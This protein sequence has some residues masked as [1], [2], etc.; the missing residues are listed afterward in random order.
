MARALRLAGEIGD[1]VVI[2]LG[3]PPEV[4]AGSLELVEQGARRAGRRLADLAVWFTCFWFVDPVPGVARRRGAWAATSFAS[5]FAQ[6]GAE[7]KFVP[8]E[9]PEALVQ[10]GAAYDYTTHGD[11]PEQQKDAYAELARWLGVAEY[12]QRRFAFCG[13]DRRRDAGRRVAFRRGHRRAAAGA[14]RPHHR[15]GRPSA[16]PAQTIGHQRRRT[17]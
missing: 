14:P 2:G 3:V 1:G 16:A 8:A 7:G 13:A 17:R 11:V 10:L 5:H 12:L 15:L 4:V 6:Q 9:M